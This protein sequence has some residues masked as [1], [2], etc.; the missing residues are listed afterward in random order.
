MF[1]GVSVLSETLVQPNFSS[2]D[3]KLTHHK[4]IKKT[5]GVLTKA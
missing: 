1:P 3:C 2:P 4:E 5:A